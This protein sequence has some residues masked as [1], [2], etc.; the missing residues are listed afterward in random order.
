MP[1]GTVIQPRPTAPAAGSLASRLDSS[2]NTP[3]LPWRNLDPTLAAKEGA[4]QG[5]TNMAGVPY[6][7]PAFPSVDDQGQPIAPGTP[8]PVP[9]DYSGFVPGA[10]NQFKDGTRI[11]TVT[12][13]T[14]VIKNFPGDV[15]G[16]YVE[17]TSNPNA[18]VKSVRGSNQSEDKF[19]LNGR[20]SYANQID[21][22]MPLELGGADTM[23]NREV[24]TFEQNQQKTVAQAVPYT[25]YTHGLLS[26]ADARTMAMTWKN[27]DI[28]GLPHPD[29]LGMVPLKQAQD[30]AAR[31]MMPE[32]QRPKSFAQQMAAIPQEAK[33]FGK[34]WLPDPIREFVKGFGSG[35]SFGFL[36]YQQGEDESMVSKIAGWAGMT[37][38]GITSFF[39]GGEIL[40]AGLY[41]TAAG[42]RVLGALSGTARAAAAAEG[43]VSAEAALQTAPTLGSRLLTALKPGVQVAKTVSTE[44]PDT[45][46]YNI[47]RGMVSPLT[48]TTVQKAG[49][50]AATSV[51][52]GQVNQYVQHQF[53]PDILS[54]KEQPTAEPHMVTQIIK[55]AVLGGVAGVAS[56]T[57]KGASLAMAPMLVTSYIEDPYH[58]LNAFTNAAVFGAF[59]LAGAG[60]KKAEVAKLKESF[61]T[62]AATPEFQKYQ[63]E[64]LN[65]PAHNVMNYWAGAEIFP[66]VKP[67]EPVP[68]TTPE[69]LISGAEKAMEALEVR[70]NLDVNPDGTPAGKGMTEQQYKAEKAKIVS[71]VGQLKIATLA[72]ELQE[73]ATFENIVSFAKMLKDRGKDAKGKPLGSIFDQLKAIDVPT[74]TTDVAKHISDNREAIT[75]GQA[76]PESTGKYLSTD[77]PIVGAVSDAQTD[78]MARFTSQEPGWDTLPYV[79]IHTRP[80]LENLFKQKNAYLQKYPRLAK[81]KAQ[82]PNPQNVGQ[83]FGYKQNQQT[84]QIKTYSIGMIAGEP[85]L[86]S[87]PLAI[88]KRTQGWKNPPPP[89]ESSK[90]DIIPA[91]DKAGVRV[92]F[93]SI[94]NTRTT[95]STVKSGM[96][97][98]VGEIND[99]HWN[100]AIAMRDKFAQNNI[101]SPVSLAIAENKHSQNA[102]TVSSAIQTI[103]EKVTHD[104]TNPASPQDL[105]ANLKRPT[106]DLVTTPEET[107]TIF[108]ERQ[109]PAMHHALETLVKAENSGNGKAVMAAKVQI[110][111]VL[112]TTK[113][114]KPIPPLEDY[115][116]DASVP[117]TTVNDAKVAVQP[118]EVGVQTPEVTPNV[119]EVT[120]N[121]GSATAMHDQIVSAARINPIRKVASF[122]NPSYSDI[123]PGQAS[124]AATEAAKYYV[125]EGKNAIDDATPQGTGAYQLKNYEKMFDGTISGALNRAQVDLQKR[126]MAQPMIDQVKEQI[127]TELTNSKAV[128][129]DALKL[130]ASEEMPPNDSEILKEP[131]EFMPSNAPIHDPKV[132]SRETFNSIREGLTSPQGTLPHT[133][134][135]VW[136]AVLTKI[137][138]KDYPKNVDAARAM[139]TV[140]PEGNNFWNKQ[141]PSDVNS[142]GRP[143]TQPKDVLAARAQGK[144]GDEIHAI[145]TRS[146]LTKDHPS[147]EGG[148]LSDKELADLGIGSTPPEEATEGGETGSGFP[149]MKVKSQM[150]EEDMVHD[151][152]HGEDMMA[153]ISSDLPLSHVGVV[154]DIKNIWLGA[155][156]ENPGL[157]EAISNY[158]KANGKRGLFLDKKFFDPFIKQ[159]M[160]DD[161]EM[162][163]TSDVPTAETA[164]ESRS[165]KVQAALQKIIKKYIE[166]AKTK[167]PAKTTTDDGHPISE[168]TQSLLSI[169]GAIEKDPALKKRFETLYKMMTK[170]DG[171]GGPGFQTPPLPV[172]PPSMPQ[173]T[174]MFDMNSM[175]DNRNNYIV[176]SAKSDYPFTPEAQKILSSIKYARTPKFQQSDL[177][178]SM[179]SNGVMG[180]YTEGGKW[181]EF[182][183]MGT[184]IHPLNVFKNITQG[185]DK[186]TGAH[187]TDF[188]GHV[189]DPERITLKDSDYPDEEGVISHE[190]LH[191]LYKNSPMHKDPTKWANTWDEISSQFPLLQSIDK[192]LEDAGYDTSDPDSV[193]TERFAYLG[194]EVLHGG[195]NRIPAALRPFYT[196][197]IKDADKL[198]AKAAP[199]M[200][201]MQKTIESA[202]PVIKNVKIQRT[203]KKDGS[204]GPGIFSNIVDA[205]T[206]PFSNTVS[207][208]AP[209]QATSTPTSSYTVRGMKLSNDDLSEASNILYSEVSNREPGRQQFETKNI[210]N[211]ALNRMADRPGKTL[212]Q[213]LQQPNQYQGYAPN[214]ITGKDG[215]TVQSQYQK[216]KAGS[217]DSMSQKKLKIIQ[218]TLNGLKSGEFPDTTAGSQFYV[219]ASDGTMWLGKTIDEAKRNANTH[220]KKIKSRVTSWGG[221]T[222]A[223]VMAS[224][225]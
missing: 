34:G 144:R 103:S 41:A 140:S 53:N 159:A 110:V 19:I 210:I 209:P 63:F 143:I 60:S 133:A 201:R 136:D 86:N 153:G 148:T 204:G 35:A 82:D 170:N 26:L 208:T 114:K 87:D 95:P 169:K 21:H 224:T 22:I 167:S 2:K 126:G 94:D 127:E 57:L 55:D 132:Y 185:I 123:P 196:G 71:A 62:T 147:G 24:L 160:K 81:G 128:R 181:P 179:D 113:A 23:A 198:P 88:N 1:V 213:I 135:K 56:P 12:P 194:Q 109:E 173:S 175:L 112:K 100:D 118:P 178:E 117:Q 78:L 29:N 152:T 149:G 222:G 38:G 215:K 65:L 72:P 168:N 121:D 111:K 134:A 200:Q 75:T 59:H 50:F 36:P 69:N 80:D 102:K 48:K 207:Y 61:N 96:P 190:M 216:V 33:D 9:S 25:L 13:K 89:I 108:A 91:M 104:I 67:G 212:T 211:T 225:L 221:A 191:T 177:P 20:P 156:R 192:H 218:D 54:G 166:E 32:A 220:E 73:R 6:E 138:G 206:S 43:L 124:S 165:P 164:K 139:S 52:T 46:P 188:V 44:V 58:P 203:N 171:A 131:K 129:M 51:L 45:L 119:P 97:F 93:A 193:G 183:V 90:D 106:I 76:A 142:S 74:I 174:P 155:S 98:L 3:A 157:R 92:L 151:L 7:Q 31:W 37:A 214:G 120:P 84:G 27:R 116:V 199:Q 101:Q 197:F 64:K 85:Y 187:T 150:Q 172:L 161:A 10:D 115:P 162:G 77:F 219:H 130:P 99:Q 107:Q 145:R 141:F 11:T 49:K 40:D 180:E 223:P 4:V 189:F 17:D 217:L 70:H 186:V 16:Q 163:A 182:N 105:A 184:Q 176:N 122:R 202:L 42:A 47:F 83:V 28:G 195:V 146:K 158:N 30:V 66:E 14:P 39:L 5:Y 125:E 15:Q 18:L 137:F 68:V 79:S 205:I 8:I 154:N